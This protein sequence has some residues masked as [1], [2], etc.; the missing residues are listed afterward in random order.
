MAKQEGDYF[1]PLCP[2]HY[3]VMVSYPKAHQAV[4]EGSE[5]VDVHGRECPVDGCLQNYSPG[6]GYFTFGRNN[7]FWVGTNSSSLRIA[8]SSTQVLCG[9]HKDTM[10]IE[11]FDANRNVE[12]FRCP[13]TGCHQTMQ[14]PTGGPPAYWL[15]QGYFGAPVE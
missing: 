10:F 4:F 11:S 13:Q 2:E 5:G 15:G 1:R 9:E 6:F 8:R 3:E 7:D 12:T 14:I